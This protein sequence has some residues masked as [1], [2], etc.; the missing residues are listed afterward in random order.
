MRKRWLFLVVPVLAAACYGLYLAAEAGEFRTVENIRPGAC[1]TVAGLP[2]P[3]DIAVHPARNVAYVSSFDRRAALDGDPRPGAIFR[4]GPDGG[5]PVNLAPDAGPSFRPHG[6]SLHVDRDGRETLFV[7]NHPGETLF[8][9]APPDYEGP[10]HTI[11]VFDI[12]GDRL[13]RRA[14]LSDPLLVRPND[15]AAVDGTR[16]YVTND[17]GSEPGPMRKVED[18]LRLPWANVVFYDGTTFREVA[19]G[20][21]YAN[22]INLSRDG[23]RVWVAEVTRSRIREYRRDP[24]RGSLAETRRVD[25]GF[26]VDNISV[27]AETGDL[28]LAGH[29][30]LLK[31][32]RHAADADV[33]APSQVE[34]LRFDDDE[35]HRETVFVDDGSLLSGASVAV[36]RDGQLLIGA[37]FSPHAVACTIDG[38]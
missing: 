16:F 36:R 17:H 25:V 27:D 15:V 3:E 4:I 29:L 31:F 32:A 33:D 22:G 9:D 26:G 5:G 10:A 30:K 2:G 14:R 12:A 34:R 13:V 24:K 37:V 18:Y 38:P 28:W 6:I 21:T 35:V 1:R 19:G 23:R 20:L 8:G 7:V 11:E